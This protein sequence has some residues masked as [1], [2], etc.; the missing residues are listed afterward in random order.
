MTEDNSSYIARTLRFLDSLT[1]PALPVSLSRCCRAAGVELTSFSSLLAGGFTREE[2]LALA[3]NRD[4]A[5]L[6]R[7]EHRVILYNDGQPDLRCRFTVAEELMHHV[8]GHPRSASFSVLR[9]SYSPEEY[10][11]AEREAKGAA[12]LLL[13]P[14]A[15]YLRRRPDL[16]AVMRRCR[17]SEA[18]AVHIR[19]FYAENDAEIRRCFRCS[20]QR[21]VFYSG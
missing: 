3:G 8:L 15:Y 11:A 13:C 17:V 7:G 6:C 16:T 20:H 18:C 21:D 5:C 12:C 1:A 14:P 19:R 10:A 9:Q 4:G 2:V